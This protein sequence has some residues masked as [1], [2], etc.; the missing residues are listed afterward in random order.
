[1]K[2]RVVVTIKQDVLDPE[3]QAIQRA[4]QSLGYSGV[5]AVRQGKIFEITWE[6]QDVNGAQAALQ[7]I[8]ERLLANPVIEDFRVERIELEG[9]AG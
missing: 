2:A 3:G 5:Q 1:V 9:G 6:G 8:A 7:E 4:C